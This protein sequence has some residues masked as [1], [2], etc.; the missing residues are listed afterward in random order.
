MS[1]RR[2]SKI[3]FVSVTL[4][5][6]SSLGRGAG[7]LLLSI[8]W[9]VNSRLYPSTKRIMMLSSSEEEISTLSFASD[10]PISLTKSSTL[11]LNL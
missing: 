4:V 3:D 10:L 9:M 5:S 6:N 11:R 2:R 1:P 8:R 7:P